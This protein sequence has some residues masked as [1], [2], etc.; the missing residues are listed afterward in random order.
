MSKR[1]GRIAFTFCVVALSVFAFVRLAK[2]CADPGDPFDDY[3][4]HP[5]APLEK[6]AQGHLGVVQPTFARSYLVVAYRYASGVPLT[7]DEQA[8]AEA[9]WQSRAIDPTNIY[10][11]YFSGGGA[12]A[13]RQ[14]NYL[15][16]AQD[17]ADGPKDWAGARAEIVSSPAPHIE[18]MQSLD[19]YNSY[20]NCSNDAFATAAVTLKQRAAK[21]G[22]DNPGV[23]DWVAAQDTVFANCGG[24]PDHPAIPAAADPALPE[25]LRYDREYQIAAAYM[26]SNH[27]DEAVKGFHHIAEEPNSPWH[28][29]APYLVARTMVRC[30]TLDGP[31]LG[32]AKPGDPLP[33]SFVREEMQ[34]AADYITKLLAE[35]PNRPFA[36]PL[37][38][39][40]DRAEFRLRPVERTSLLSHNLSNPAPDGHFYNWLWDY[41]LLLDSPG[42]AMVEYSGTTRAEKYAK[43]VEDRHKD[44]LSDW[45]M[46]FQLR[47]PLNAQH[48]LEVWHAHRDSVPWLFAVLSKS[49]PNSPDVSVFYHRMRLLSAMH[50]YPEARRSIDAFLASSSDLPAVAKDFL[51]DLRLDAASDLNDAVRFLPR[52]TC[53]VYSRKAPPDCSRTLPEHSAQYL[54]AM[55]LDLMIDTLQNKGLAEAEKAKFVRNVW[56]RS[57]LLGRYDVAQSLDAQAFRPGAYQAPINPDDTP[58]LV[59]AFESASTP[60]EKEFAAVFLMQ[61]QYAFS[62]G[63]G[64]TGAWCASSGAFKEDNTSWPASEQPSASFGAP[65]FITEAQRKQA[66]AERSTLDHVDSQA[67]YYTRVVLEFAKRHP[68]DPRVPEALSRAVKNTRMNCNNPR[69]PAL[70][71][72]AYDLLHK[73]YPD[74]TWAKNTKYWFGANY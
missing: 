58:N 3:S 49:Q 16:D 23:K 65:L 13:N 64:F 69:T 11:E 43:F 55:P 44:G 35:Q 39:L 45:I 21:L 18:P 34:A 70:S 25:I 26:Y 73:R 32:D 36:S 47:D 27:Y 19:T 40:L 6:F 60:E 71:K 46:T 8:A 24:N 10:P 53:S 63:I 52:D 28:D 22:K 42:I 4:R 14:N 31:Q 29:I 59:K 20:L 74:T 56:L 9:L 61:H 41:T 54:D 62:Y 66:E 1:S 15:K 37:Q 33:P 50:N 38:A 30:A 51:L 68:D 17:Y 48:T 2:S 12:E 67:N 7:K 57:V 5:D 72:A